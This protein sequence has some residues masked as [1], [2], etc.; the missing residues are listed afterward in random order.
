MSTTSRRVRLI[1]AELAA[2]VTLLFSSLYTA[3]FYDHSLAPYTG[4]ESELV[5]IFLSIVAFALCVRIRSPAVA[6]MLIAGGVIMLIPPL[7]TIAQAG[8]I[9]VPGPIFGVI[10]FLDIL[11]LGLAKAGGLRRREASGA[12]ASEK[13][14]TEA[15]IP[16]TVRLLASLLPDLSAF[17]PTSASAAVF[18]LLGFSKLSDSRNSTAAELELMSASR[19]SVGAF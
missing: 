7:Q 8:R 15:G 14:A 3:A 9:A 10:S 13:G 2:A 12:R 6:G 18:S 16:G 11:V 17:S 5:P 1:A 19:T 4:R